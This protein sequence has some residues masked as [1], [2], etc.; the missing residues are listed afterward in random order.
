MREIG[1]YV[2][3]PFC[4]R[5]C[6]YCDFVSFENDELCEK[7][8]D[9]VL[10]NIN[11][12]NIIL[13][14]NNIGELSNDLVVDTIYIGGG[15]PS[16]ISSKYIIKILKKI[17]EKFKV[18]SDA[19]I[20][21][22]VNPGTVTKEKLKAY[23]NIGVNRLSIGLQSTKNE[24]LNVI[25]RIHSFEDFLFTYNLAKDIG[26]N[27]INV[28]LMLGLPTQGIEDVV[29]S[30]R[31]IMK[32]NPEHIS[33]YSLILEK[34]TKLEK[35]VNLGILKLP[36]EETEREMYHKTKEI[37]EKNNYIHYEISNF[38][39]K[40]FY[41]KHNINCWK[42]HEYLGFGIASHS[43]F[44]NIRFNNLENLEKYI[45]KNSKQVYNKYVKICEIQSKNDMMKEFMLL[46]FRK[47]DGISFKEFKSKFDTD[48]NLYFSKEIEKLK[49]QE[50]IEIE[51][52][53]I[54]LSNK[55]LDFANL[56]FEE[57]I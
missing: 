4:K 53:Y 5:K 39:K 40:G 54:K 43:Y 29:S 9:S 55:G 7:Y 45:E 13:E 48:L 11:G 33:L 14:K 34:E 27:N 17:R 42:Q 16:F 44:N 57:F 2:H 28:D 31:E 51:K 3:I 23:Y 21:I 18:K 22:E 38:A 41:S 36:D 25:G 35:E 49:K 47:L 37:L 56:V 32:L 30:L 24:I 1:I 46:G 6:K 10:N 50:L 15:T 8:I 26:F 52:G 19:E 20:T 12:I